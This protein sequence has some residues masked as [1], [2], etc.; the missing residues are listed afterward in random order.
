MW[1]QRGTDS[2]GGAFPP[3]VVR[4]LSSQ[5]LARHAGRWRC[6]AAALSVIASVT[7]CSAPDRADAIHAEP[8]VQ[9]TSAPDPT[10]WVTSPTPL[11][12]L[13]RGPDGVLFAEVLDLAFDPA[14]SLVI[15]D[16]QSARIHFVT[17]DG[18]PVHAVGGVGSG[19]G[20]LRS[21]DGFGVSAGGRAWGYDAARRRLVVFGT[22]GGDTVT[23]SLHAMGILAW[24]MVVGMIAEDEFLVIETHRAMLAGPSGRLLRDSTRL[25]RYLIPPGTAPRMLPVATRP[26]DDLFIHPTGR[27]LVQLGFGPRLV[28]AVDP[29]RQLAYWGFSDSLLIE[30]RTPDGVIETFVEYPARRDAVS[31][32]ARD[33]VLRLAEEMLADIANDLPGRLPAFQRLLVASDGS[34]WVKEYHASQAAPS[35][36]AVF[37]TVGTLRRIVEMPAQFDL[38]AVNGDTAAGIAEDGSGEQ[39]VRVLLL[40]E[41]PRQ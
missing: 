8:W 20:E 19:P 5:L 22:N 14:G 37:D 3:A 10:R 13:A 18:V 12:D 40:V 25:I 24:P 41:A 27:R 7:S 16:H 35:R 11:W 29:V 2:R 1:R 39:F 17:P 31:P 28:V 6:G 15:A 9:G 21:I 23:T 4:V 38:R 36:W 32:A 34:L 33:S 30:R 26:R